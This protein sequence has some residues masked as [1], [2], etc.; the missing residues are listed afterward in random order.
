MKKNFFK[1][2]WFQIIL[3]LLLTIVFFYLFFREVKITKVISNLADVNLIFLILIIILTPIHLL[4]RAVRWDYLLRPEKKRISVYNLFAATT[5]GFTFSMIFPGRL[6]ELVKPLYL[7]KKENM[8]KGYVIG[9]VVVER[10]FDIFAMCSLLGLFLIVNPFYSSFFN[11]N[12]EIYSKLKYWGLVGICIASVLLIVALSLYFY[13][14][15]TLRVITFIL[16]PIPDSMLQKI[17]KIFE[18]FIEGL[19]FFHSARNLLM[20]ILFSYA[21][22]L[23]IIFYYWLMFIAY[24][25]SINI[26]I[27]FFLIFP[28]VFLTMVGASIP[29]PGMVGGF[30][31]FSKLGLTSLYGIDGNLAAAMTLVIHAVQ[32]IMTCIIGYVILWKE[33]LS[34]I[35][36]KKLSKNFK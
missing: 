4:I 16:K 2:T 28:Y 32:I 9:T 15:K 36:L 14:N 11:A 31:Y 12:E 29:T 33:G 23:W 22:W 18:E 13:K 35:Q 10:T 8:K 26:S 1:N 6:G 19:K 25:D 3:I 30:D 24:K 34:F 27:S 20:Y 21:V 7:A 5:I 17:L